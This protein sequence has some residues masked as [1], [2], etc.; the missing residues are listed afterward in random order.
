MNRHAGEVIG[1]YTLIRPLG[2]GA[3]GEVWLGKRRTLLKSD[4]KY[5]AIKLPKSTEI[6]AAL[7]RNEV[8]VWQKASG[9][10]N[11]VPLIEADEYNGQIVIVSEFL[12]DGTLDDLLEKFDR[13]PTDMAVEF[14]MRILVGLEHLHGLPE[15]IIH[16]DLKPA[17]ILFR[18]MN[19]F[20]SDFGISRILRE[21]DNSQSEIIAG[22]QLFMAPE[23]HSGKRNEQTD[24]WSVGVILYRMLTGRLPFP[25]VPAIITKKPLPVD[26]SVPV[27]LKR[28]ISR[29]LAKDPKRRFSSAYEMRSAFHHA[30]DKRYKR[31]FAL[32]NQGKFDVAIK[33]LD[34]LVALLFEPGLP[35]YQDL[36]GL[37]L[38]KLGQFQE[39][40]EAHNKAIEASLKLGDFEALKTAYNN[41]GIANYRSGNSQKA[42]EDY[43][44][45]LRTGSDQINKQVLNNRGN[46]FKKIGNMLKA[47]QDYR[48]ALAI[49]PDYFE[50]LHNL[51]L[52]PKQE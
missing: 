48:D 22:T 33:H 44:Y 30:G 5:F 12:P 18:G 34:I 51:N 3:F 15:K 41:R 7:L 27:E 35:A 2:E 38:T 40:I 43:D 52:L 50:A 26:D 13:I 21:T 49:D 17:N 39:A 11:I 47:E 37:V 46:A 29:A 9:H 6:D 10:R 42:I 45:A 4:N 28:I 19:L 25:H 31:A 23:A 32:Y 8:A 14:T 36:R 20:I 16:R 24:I 1:P